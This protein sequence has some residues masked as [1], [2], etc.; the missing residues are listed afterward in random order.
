MS[1]TISLV[2]VAMA[3][4]LDY[5]EDLDTTCCF[6][7]FQEIKE[8]PRTMQKLETDLLVLRHAAQSASP[9]DLSFNSNSADRNKPWPGLLFKYLRIL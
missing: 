1:Q 2:T 7:H 5:A 9:Y 6:L 3:L 4:Y 8:S